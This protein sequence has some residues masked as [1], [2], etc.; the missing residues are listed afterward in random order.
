MAT[1]AS[2]AEGDAYFLLRLNA[3]PWSDATTD[4]KT[5]ALN[6]ATRIID[7]LNF[8]GTRTDDDQDLQFPR[9]DDSAIPTDIVNACCELCLALLDD[10]DPD[11]E[12]ETLS[13]ARFKFADA[14]ANYSRQTVPM[15]ILAGVVSVEAWRYLI[16]YLRDPN[17][18]HINRV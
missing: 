5:R 13:M 1:Y 11:L 8:L 7:R 16:P 10:V 3:E 9:D 15:H 14:E 12:F 18:M 6:Q 2:I 17:E 4:N